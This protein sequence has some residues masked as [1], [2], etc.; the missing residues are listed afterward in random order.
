MNLQ[1]I[2]V[3]VLLATLTTACQDGG[4]DDGSNVSSSPFVA[5]WDFNC[6]HVENIRIPGPNGTQTF[7]SQTTNVQL[8]V[9]MDG[10]VEAGR[11]TFYEGI[12]GTVQNPGTRYYRSLSLASTAEGRP[13][14]SDVTQNLDAF[15]WRITG[16]F[17]QVSQTLS[18]RHYWIRE[19]GTLEYGANVR[20]LRCQPDGANRQF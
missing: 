11:L 16:H 14:V 5:L 17:D 12:G 1:K 19:D 8:N 3:S 4:S 20:I 6:Q 18:L 9:P 10:A 13:A 7:S 15:D 2:L